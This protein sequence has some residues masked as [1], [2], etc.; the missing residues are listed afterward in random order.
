MKARHG[1]ANS[2]GVIPIEANDA[3]G[4]NKPMSRV[5]IIDGVIEGGTQGKAANLDEGAICNRAVLVEGRQHAES[6]G[7]E[8][9]AEFTGFNF[10]G[11][12][13]GLKSAR[14]HEDRIGDRYR[15]VIQ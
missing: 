3:V 8:K 7:C 11:Q 15:G 10:A 4:S 2:Q 13:A 6:G 5:W 12:H 9:G 1:G 14:L